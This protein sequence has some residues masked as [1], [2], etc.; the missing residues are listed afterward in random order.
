VQSLTV[1][2]ALTTGC[3]NP[4]QAAG[5]DP[6]R[7]F[8]LGVFLG[9]TNLPRQY[10]DFVSAVGRRPAILAT[11]VPWTAAGGE[12]FPANFCRFA[13]DRGATPLI[14]W[15][16][17]DPSTHWHPLLADIAAG[18]EDDR[19]RRWASDARKWHSPVLL[20]FAHEMNGDWYPWSERRE[21]AQTAAH[22]VA[23]WRRVRAVFREARAHNV[24]FVWAP[25]CEP[26]DRIER[27]YPGPADVDWIGVDVYNHPEWPKDPAGMIEP[28][29]NFAE[30]HRKPILLTEVGC[31]E[32][33]LP[34]RPTMDAATWANKTRWINRLF[35]VM[36]RRPSIRGIVWFNV[37]KESDWRVTASPES[38]AA[39]RHGLLRLDSQ[40]V[41]K[42]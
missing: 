35:E 22:Y 7:P 42:R 20:R 26:A 19:I 28:L 27:L 41:T 11:F 39:F 8:R 36:A 3:S 32:H 6:A 25:N 31:A 29:L 5:E 15:E 14:T 37:N 24:G 2:L 13:R 33:Y 4:L 18:R 34:E 21:P 38:L 23:A 12:P 17:W 16:P 40:D 30:Q 1:S 10:D 9:D